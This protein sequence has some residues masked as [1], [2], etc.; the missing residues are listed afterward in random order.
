[1]DVCVQTLAVFD[2]LKGA[3]WDDGQL[4]MLL[5]FDGYSLVGKVEWPLT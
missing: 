5:N 1:M 2:D 3:R 4:N